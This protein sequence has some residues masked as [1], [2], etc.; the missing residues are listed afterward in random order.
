MNQYLITAFDYTDSG[1]LQRRMIARPAHLEMMRK[2]KETGNY[3]LGGAILNNT[4]EMIGSSIIVQFEKDLDVSAW[5][6]QEPYLLQ[7]VWEKVDFKPFR[8]AVLT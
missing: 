1:T 6:A 4:G 7:K 2:L 3:I 8:V 5:L